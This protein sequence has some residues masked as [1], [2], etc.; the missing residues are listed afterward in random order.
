ML[1]WLGSILTGRAAPARSSEPAAGS[2]EAATPS[3][4]EIPARG[5]PE[6]TAATDGP[7]PTNPLRADEAEFLAGLVE[8]PPCDPED[9]TTLARMLAKT[10]HSRSP[11][12]AAE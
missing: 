8:P 6:A 11:V 1:K 7:E 5:R 4:R 3:V 12:A 2:R 10:F 9:L